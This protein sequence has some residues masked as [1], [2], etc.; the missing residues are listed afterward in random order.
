MYKLE[1][2]FS[3]KTLKG[4]NFLKKNQLKRVLAGSL[5]GGAIF[6]FT[7]STTTFS[8]STALASD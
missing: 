2:V 6:S 1:I 5:I 3:K 4:E 7:A 8:V